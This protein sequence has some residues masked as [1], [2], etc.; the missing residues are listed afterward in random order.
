[1]HLQICGNTCKHSESESQRQF[2]LTSQRKASDPQKISGA[3]ARVTKAVTGYPAMISTTERS[4]QRLT[5]FAPPRTNAAA[6]VTWALAG[7]TLQGF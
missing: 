4:G 7:L 5:G 3:S 1:M 6:H 2:L